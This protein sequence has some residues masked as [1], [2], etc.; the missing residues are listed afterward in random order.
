LDVLAG[1]RIW[2]RERGM[3]AS[4]STPL[5]RTT[6]N[7]RGSHKDMRESPCHRQRMMDNDLSARLPGE[8]QAQ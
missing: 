1:T 7:S 4:T 3:K 5:P 6:L 8:M 2:T